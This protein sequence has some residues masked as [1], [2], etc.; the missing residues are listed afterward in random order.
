MF[1]NVVAGFTIIRE[2]EGKGKQNRSTTTKPADPFDGSLLTGHPMRKSKCVWCHCRNKIGTCS[3]C[4]EN[5]SSIPVKFFFSTEIFQY[6]FKVIYSLGSTCIA[7]GKVQLH[8]PGKHSGTPSGSP[9]PHL[10]WHESKNHCATGI[11]TL[12]LTFLLSS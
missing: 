11:L 8:W 4:S 3:S 12:F 9:C 2:M 10:T 5:D 7:S 1:T 6:G